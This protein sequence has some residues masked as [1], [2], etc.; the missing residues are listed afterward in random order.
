MATPGW[1]NENQ[2]RDYPFITRV[3]PLAAAG[4]TEDPVAGTTVVDMPKG[5]V[6]DFVAVMEPGAE[7]DE[8]LGHSIWLSRLTRT[9]TQLT[10][11]FATDAPGAAGQDLVFTR[12][13]DDS[14]FVMNWQEAALPGAGAAPSCPAAPTWRG[15]LVTGRLGDM[16]SLIVDGQ[17][18]LLVDKMWEVEPAA[19]Q[20][21]RASMLQGLHLANSPRT[22]ATAPEGCSQSSAAGS[23]D[24][25]LQASC[26]T[27]DVRLKPGYNCYVRQD[28][29]NNTLIVEAAVGAGAG[30]PCAE[31]PLYAGET[32]PAGSPYLSGGPG[33]S[34][35]L[36]T[37]N[38]VGGQELTLAAGPGFRVYADPAITNKLIVERTIEPFTSTS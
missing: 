1:Y 9:G 25:I 26:V 8:S 13:M 31:V 24:V 5:A 20:N 3:R 34:E 22:M 12:E 21:L 35:I 14:E 33:C 6:V 16:T 19:V 18:V 38:G 37:V 28:N 30:E 2:F 11:T 36:K 10:L 4:F 27:G 7:Y 32:P 23:D 17:D 29:I 15:F